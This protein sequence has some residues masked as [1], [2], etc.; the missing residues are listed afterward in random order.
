MNT[1]EWN[2]QSLDC[3]NRFKKKKKDAKTNSPYLLIREMQWDTICHFAKLDS[4]V[5]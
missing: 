3:P 1:P 5:P 4:E 2:G